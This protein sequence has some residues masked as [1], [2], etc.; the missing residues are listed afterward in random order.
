MAIDRKIIAEQ[1]YGPGGVPTCNV[2]S[3][4]PAVVSKTND[5]CLTQDI[6]G[7]K[8]LLDDSGYVD[9][10]GDGI[11]ETKDGKPI[12]DSLPDVDQFGA[13]EDAGIGPAMV[14]GNRH[15]H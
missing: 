10:N 13:P 8:K 5:A 6:E 12:E 1:L 9:T 7:A 11:R 2:L 14:E 4:P 15:R 3:G